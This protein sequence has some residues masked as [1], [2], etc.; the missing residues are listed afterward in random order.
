MLVILLACTYISFVCLLWGTATFQIFKKYLSNQNTVPHFSIL[1]LL[2][3]TGIVCLAGLFSLFMPLGKWY[4]HVF[5]LLPL[6]FTFSSLKSILEQIIKKNFRITHTLSLMLL[7]CCCVLLLVMASWQIAHPDTLGYHIQ[8]IEWIENYRVI[9]G[10]VH[11]NYRYG[12][13][14]LW[15]PACALFNFKPLGVSSVNFLNCAATFW[16]VFF[17]IKKMDDSLKEKDMAAG[18]LWL[19]LLIISFWNYTQVRL[20][21]TSASPD[22]IVTILIW[23]IVYLFLQKESYGNF[24][25]PLLCF[26]AITIKL[27]SLPIIVFAVYSLL[28]LLKEKKKQLFFSTILFGLLVISS[29]V[30]RN[31]ITTGYIAFPSPFPDIITADWKL[32]KQLTQQGKNYITAYARIAGVA[33]PEEIKTTI[34]MRPIEWLPVWWQNRSASDKIIII[35]LLV[36]FAASMIRLKKILQAN[37]HTKIALLVLLTGIIFWFYNAP[38]PRFGAGFIIGFIAI[39][40][41][42]SISEIFFFKTITAKKILL[43]GVSTVLICLSTYTAYRFMNF[44]THKQFISPLGI[45]QSFFKTVIC[46]GIKIKIPL[47]G[48]TRENENHQETDCEK[49][50]LRGSKITDGFKA[51]K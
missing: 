4:V 51:S 25:I 27:S 24:I 20:T 14:G 19:A 11:L 49:F 13:Q 5:L 18:F 40:S 30:T 47:R 1:C 32:D 29:F 28:V 12:L 44:Y 41:N 10:L 9:P 22:F 50:E 26:T 21:T 42:V 6:V 43:G 7:S 15:F 8:T 16:F 45:E 48:R 31:I 33:T 36:A 46:N 38:D 23:A 34:Q 37:T 39:I 3:L 2:G 35:S 17:L